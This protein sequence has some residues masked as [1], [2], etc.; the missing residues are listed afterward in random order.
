MKWFFF[1]LFKLLRSVTVQVSSNT[2]NNVMDY[3]TSGICILLQF[4]IENSESELKWLKLY[5]RAKLNSAQPIM[6]A[7]HFNTVN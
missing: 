2:W 6:G 5:L 4:K 7:W 3:K 1:F